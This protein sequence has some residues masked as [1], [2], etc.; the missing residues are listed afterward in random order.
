M[1]FS[2]KPTRRWY[3]LGLG[4]AAGAAFLILASSGAAPEIEVAS[5]TEP[6]TLLVAEPRVESVPFER[7]EA[8]P[9]APS[10]SSNVDRAIAAP[11]APSVVAPPAQQ[12]EDPV[13]TLAKAELD[14]LSRQ[15]PENFLE[16][17]DVMRGR[18]GDAPELSAVRRA[19]QEYIFER[20]ALLKTMLDR[21]VDDPNAD[22]GSELEKLA[23]LDAAF[24]NELQ[25]Y[26]RTIP[27]V[28]NFDEVLTTTSLELPSAI[29]GETRDFPERSSVALGPKPTEF[30][31]TEPAAP[32]EETPTLPL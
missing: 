2:N 11:V 26:A 22:H 4:A 18:Y 14:E 5:R 28:A 7:R 9:K 1:R 10:S 16:I 3:F 8:T 12:L 32:T 15:E 24:K 17:F 29:T 13:V 23:R 19:T 6:E 25:W 20:T 21:A 31:A 30:D 27:D